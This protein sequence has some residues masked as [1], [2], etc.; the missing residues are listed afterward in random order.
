MEFKNPKDLKPKEARQLA[1]DLQVRMLDIENCLDDLMRAVEIAQYSK[2][3][4]VTE[5]YVQQATELLQNRLVV[6]EID[7]GPFKATIVESSEE[8]LEKALD[9]YNEDP[10]IDKRKHENII[11]AVDQDGTSHVDIKNSKKRGNIHDA[12]A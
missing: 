4:N 8:G 11:G 7:Q 10:T 1:L 9:I 6:P 3:Y 5:V 2:Q 12:K